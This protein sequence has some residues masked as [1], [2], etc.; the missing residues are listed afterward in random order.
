MIIPIITSSRAEATAKAKLLAKDLNG[1]YVNCLSSRPYTRGRNE[2][3]ILDDF[4][5]LSNNLVDDSFVAG[6]LAYKSDVYLVGTLI[7]TRFH[8][9]LTRII[10]DVYPE[11][12]I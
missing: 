6:L 7:H 8:P 2:P 12:F 3:L 4:C 1:L 10:S 11:L 9:T 5:F